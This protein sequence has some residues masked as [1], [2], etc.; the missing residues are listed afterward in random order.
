MYKKI[1]EMTILIED[2]ADRIDYI[3]SEK[4]SIWSGIEIDIKPEVNE[5]ELNEFKK[6]I[7]FLEED[8]KNLKKIIG[9]KNE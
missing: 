9:E 1:V 8:I 2:M 4:N 5:E 7:I 3:K 6:Q